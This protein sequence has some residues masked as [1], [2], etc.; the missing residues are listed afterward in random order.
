LN[1]VAAFEKQKI[2]G[3]RQFVLDAEMTANPEFAR[4][5][6]SRNFE[7]PGLGVHH[8]SIFVIAI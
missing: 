6:W 7:A 2:E 8:V 4:N 5:R 1:L 3:L